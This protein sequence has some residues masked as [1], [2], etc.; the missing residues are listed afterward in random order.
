[1][2]SGLHDSAIII[3][4]LI[5]SNWS[6]AVFE[7]MRRGG[8]TAA[9]CTCSIWEGFQGTM[10]NIAQWKAWF[11]EHSDLLLQVH[12]TADIRRAK[13]AG[14]TGIILGWQNTS[15][16]ED[17]ADYLRVF[18]DL[19]VLVMQL[20]YNTQNFVGSGC[21]E[22]R[23]G[24]LSDFG[25]D[26]IDEMNRLGILIDLSHVG[27]ETSKDAIRHSQKPV[28]FT[29]CCPAGLKKIP[30][31]KTDDQLRLIAEKGG[32]VGIATIAPFFPAGQDA[33]IDDYLGALE[34]TIKIAGEEHV[35][36]GTDFTQDQSDSFFEWICRDKGGGRKL[37]DLGVPSQTRMTLKG[38]DRIG[39]YPNLTAAMKRRKW[40]E[41]RIR[42]V[43]GENWLAFLKEVWGA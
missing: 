14:K 38:L 39:D 42:R 32:F 35:G 21:Y 37:V 4:G 26:V 36:I 13:E 33:T 7:D 28:A 11:V 27:T 40:S 9:N 12:T 8:L 25:R 15:G 6:R 29:H 41:A 30:R 16:I 22:S 19:G 43:L 2:A 5:V 31:N 23:D 34:Y 1:M 10:R 18:R 17:R 20:T 3:D 24:G